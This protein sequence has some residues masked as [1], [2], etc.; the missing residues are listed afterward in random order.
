MWQGGFDGPATRFENLAYMPST[1]RKIF[2]LIH[3]ETERKKIY[4]KL[5]QLTRMRENVF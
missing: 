2:K 1:K 5:T 3:N 4:E